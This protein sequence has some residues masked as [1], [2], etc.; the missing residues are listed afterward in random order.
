MA[1]SKRVSSNRTI[2][3]IELLVAILEKEVLAAMDALS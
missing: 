2:P 3:E 1:V